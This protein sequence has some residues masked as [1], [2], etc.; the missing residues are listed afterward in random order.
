MFRKQVRRHKEAPHAEAPRRRQ[1]SRTPLLGVCLC[2]GRL[3]LAWSP[4]VSKQAVDFL[5]INFAH[6]RVKILAGSVRAALTAGNKAAANV[7]ISVI[8]KS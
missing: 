3:P 2:G 6:G 4:V 8:A 1:K 5:A 7:K